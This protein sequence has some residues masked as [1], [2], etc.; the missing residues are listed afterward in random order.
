MDAL[1]QEEARSWAGS[2]L[3]AEARL[4]WVRTPLKR[5]YH[6]SFGD[7]TEFDIILCG[8]RLDGT[9]RWGET[10]PL[11]GYGRETVEDAWRWS[12]DAVE[13]V[14][15]WYSDSA[16]L[17]AADE[18]TRRPF[19]AAALLGALESSCLAADLREPFTAPVVAA[20]PG[21]DPEE[22]AEHAGRLA[23]EGFTTLKLKVGRDPVSDA[24][25]A[26]R[27]LRALPPGV[28]LRADANQAFDLA[29]ALKVWD[30][31]DHPA[32]EHLEQPFPRGDWDSP[33]RLLR[34]RPGARICLDE[35]VWLPEDVERAL[36][37]G[38]GVSV[39]LKLMK[40]S[41]S[42]RTLAMAARLRQTGRRVYF[43]NGVQ[44]EVGSL[45]EVALFKKMGLEG[46]AEIN[47]FAKQALNLI[48]D[49]P[50]SID[51]GKLMLSPWHQE[52][53]FT[54][55]LEDAVVRRWESGV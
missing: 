18:S 50:L 52:P 33:A 28:C 4:L 34:E 46:A 12:R 9:W 19:C 26:A 23:A 38:Q 3:I 31:L 54:P 49:F 21:R 22:M 36:K 35:S 39:K 16:L 25:R 30:V 11:P 32:V 6:L 43:G 8:L 2:S 51:K 17:W 48:K 29:G 10:T 37:L 27:V 55:R 45:A 41:S 53:R 24:E 47:G 7:L 15:G 44:G 14:L 40:Q 20:I 42:W 13:H 1:S 5:P